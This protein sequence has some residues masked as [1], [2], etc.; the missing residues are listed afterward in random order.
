MTLAFGAYGTSQTNT[1]LIPAQEG[2]IIRVVKVVVSSW[3]AMRITFVSDPGPDPLNLTPPLYIGTGSP[4][5]LSLGR[6]LAVTTQR[7]KALGLT[8]SYQSMPGE[9]SVAVW[10]EVVT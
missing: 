3:S 9:C 2:R 10:Y 6:A 8:T 1:I 5:V 7:G 4:F